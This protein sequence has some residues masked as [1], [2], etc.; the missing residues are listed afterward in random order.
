M[1]CYGLP[2]TKTKN[3]NNKNKREEREKKKSNTPVI[4]VRLQKELFISK[5]QTFTV[6]G[7]LKLPLGDSCIIPTH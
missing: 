1:K 3:S 7:D 6:P 5:C 4:L 2:E